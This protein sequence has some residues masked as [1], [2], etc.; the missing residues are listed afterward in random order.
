MGSKFIIESLSDRDHILKKPAMYIST[1]EPD[2]CARW[3][4]DDNVGKIVMKPVL[5]S[6][7]FLKIVD[8]V[9]SNAS[10]HY[11]RLRK[12]QAKDPETVQMTKIDIKV[13]E[14]GL[15]TV[16]NNGNGISTEPSPDGIYQAEKAYSV[17]RSSSSFSSTSTGSMVGTHGLGVKLTMTM[18]L[19]A[20]VESVDAKRQEKFA[21][22][23]ADNL[24]PEKTSKAKITK[25]TSAPYTQVE[26]MP[27]Y[28]RLGLAGGMTTDVL[29]LLHLRVLSMIT[30]LPGDVSLSFN[31]KTVRERG[32][33]KFA[34]MFEGT[35]STGMFTHTSITNSSTFWE[36]VCMPSLDNRPVNVSFVNGGITKDHGK[37]FKYASENIVKQFLSVAKDKKGGMKDLTA[38]AVKNG[39]STFVF[40]NITNPTYPSQAK[41]SWEGTAASMPKFTDVDTKSIDKM[42]KYQSL[43]DATVANKAVK[44]SKAESM[45]KGKVSSYVNISD[46]IFVD[47]NMAGRR[48]HSQKCCLIL[49]EGNSALANAR[50][51]IGELPH[52][53]DYFGA[54]A[55]KG[56]PLNV[57]NATIDQISKNE[58]MLAVHKALGLDPSKKDTIVTDL[59]Y[60]GIRLLMDFDLDGI[61]H[62]TPL[63]LNFFLEMYPNLAKSENFIQYIITPLIKVF[64]NNKTSTVFY[65]SEEF[66]KWMATG[67][68]KSSDQVKYYK[69]IA[70]SE[71]K[72]MIE[73]FTTQKKFLDF[74]CETESDIASMKLLFDKTKADDRKA[75]LNLYRDTD[76]V[77][78]NTITSINYTDFVNNGTKHYA[79]YTLK[80]AIPH[81]MDGLKDSQRKIVFGLLAMPG[82]EVDSASAVGIRV[83]QLAGYISKEADYHHGEASLQDAIVK[84]GQTYVG[85]NNINLIRPL[86]Q[87]GTRFANGE[88]A[89]QPRYINTTRPAYIKTLFNSTDNPILEQQE[90]E[91]K[92]IEP[93]WYAPIIPMLLVNGATGIA[94][95]YS[96]NIPQY[97]PKDLIKYI[98]AKLSTSAK[99]LPELHP[100][101]RGHVGHLMKID[102]KHYASQGKWVWNSDRHVVTVTEIPIGISINSYLSYLKDNSAELRKDLAPVTSLDEDG[103]PTVTP[104]AK[105]KAKAK[106]TCTK[107]VSGMTKQDIVLINS[108]MDISNESKDEAI[109]IVIRVTDT[110]AKELNAVKDHNVPNKQLANMLG[111]WTEPSDLKLTNMHALSPVT[112]GIKKY[113]SAYEILD[114]FIEVRIELYQKRKD[115][116]IDCLERK[117]AIDRAI[118]T[119][120]RAVNAN[121]IELK[122]MQVKEIVE[123]LTKNGY[124]Q[125]DNAYT[126]I[127][128]LPATSLTKERLTDRLSKIEALEAQLNLIKKKTPKALWIDDLDEFTDLHG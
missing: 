114:E 84:M 53:R 117:L 108:P 69:G 13:A 18:A 64:H 113:E 55:L 31:G 73:Y 125:K 1:P 41:N 119:Y 71:K 5:V 87:F 59:R 112:G 96:T 97:C 126:Y 40:M 128:D 29:Q 66:D 61:G 81:L 60:G 6:D 19:H 26:F 43:I 74:K 115:Y 120:I 78:Y 86:G 99:P 3:V 25:F 12:L 123:F 100:W 56:K 28:K 52:G 80:R 35:T 109:K 98:K 15:I 45:T 121:L 21:Q 107:R 50:A 16:R 14:D 63:V 85:S 8:E 101:I 54:L 37:H 94:T 82:K 110:A 89:G 103:N 39:M 106:A 124:V 62:I 51:V 127:L 46:N 42:F 38:K 7:G 58:E 102:D 104:K 90:S 83:S 77:P 79:M 33:A 91:G 27:D 24:N 32:L 20:R 105:S 67:Q 47:A 65:T 22:E 68:R 57:T 88:D 93:K 9:I 70:T 111:L 23:Y 10:D 95:G 49:C 34:L 30:Y 118:V 116:I 44:Q 72:E 2:L 11:F 76:T 17:Y 48:G 92:Q 122:N 75:W 36:V 4:Y